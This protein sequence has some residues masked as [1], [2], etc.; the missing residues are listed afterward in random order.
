MVPP[1]EEG[2]E[3]RLGEEY[4]VAVAVAVSKVS[5]PAAKVALAHADGYA[6]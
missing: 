2:G 1:F 4:L 5:H 6:R 3:V